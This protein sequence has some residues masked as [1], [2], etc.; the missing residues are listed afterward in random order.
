[1]DSLNRY[2]NGKIWIQEDGIEYGIAKDLEDAG[3]PKSE[4]VLGFQPPDVRPFTEY[5]VA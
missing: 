4:I 2:R 1:M 5:A 3:I